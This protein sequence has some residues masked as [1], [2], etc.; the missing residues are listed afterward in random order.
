MFMTGNLTGAPPGST[1]TVTYEHSQSE[2]THTEITTT[3]AEGHYQ[4]SYV[5]N[6]A[7]NWAITARYAGTDQYAPSETAPCLINSG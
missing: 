1:V 7:G 5:G 2:T 6:R 4:T 3:D